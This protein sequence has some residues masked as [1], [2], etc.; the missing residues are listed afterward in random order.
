MTIERHEGEAQVCCDHCPASYPNTYQLEDWQV[1][2]ADAKAAG[3]SIRPVRPTDRA[4]TQD[5]FAPPATRAPRSVR[6]GRENRDPEPFTHAC[7]DCAA[8]TRSPGR[9]GGGLL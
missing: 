9:H 6:P 5:L 7:P 1:M 2:I 4:G 8:A 3:W